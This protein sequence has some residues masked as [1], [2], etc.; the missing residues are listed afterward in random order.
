MPFLPMRFKAFW[1]RNSTISRLRSSPVSSKTVI[2][3]EARSAKSNDPGHALSTHALQSFLAA[4]LHDLEARL[5]SR[6]Q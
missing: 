2:L 6:P 1:P 3:S 5:K 4:E